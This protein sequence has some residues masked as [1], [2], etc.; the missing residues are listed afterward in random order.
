MHNADIMFREDVTIDQLVD[1]LMGNRKYVPCLYCYNKIDQ[2]S[3][4]G[5]VVLFASKFLI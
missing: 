2:I 3:L 1:V 4:E 5:A